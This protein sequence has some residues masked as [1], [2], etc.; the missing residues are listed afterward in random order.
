MAQK[1][2]ENQE[3]D[4]QL[5]VPDS[6]YKSE[7]N[8]II[9][10]LVKDVREIQGILCMP[11]DKEFANGSSNEHFDNKMDYVMHMIEKGKKC[12]CK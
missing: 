2:E 4:L 8:K 7:L 9:L 10:D 5:P 6:V 1:Q 3:I 12:K 11:I